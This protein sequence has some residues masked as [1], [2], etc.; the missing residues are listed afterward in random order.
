MPRFETL[1]E[2]NERARVLGLEMGTLIDGVVN[3]AKPVLSFY[4][5]FMVNYDV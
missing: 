4:S 2:V 1:L 5:R 3:G